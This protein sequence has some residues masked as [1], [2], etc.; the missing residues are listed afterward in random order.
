[1]YKL[2]LYLIALFLIAVPYLQLPGMM[3][4][5]SK[6]VFQLILLLFTGLV[7]LIPFIKK[8]KGKSWQPSAKLAFGSTFTVICFGL[9]FT[10]GLISVFLASNI[11]FATL[12]FS[13]YFLL[14][15]LVYI[16]A[17]ATLKQH[18]LL[19]KLI[20]AT[21]LIY[22]SVYMVIFF[23]N[24]ISS[25]FNP[26]IAM[27]PEKYDFTL[28]IDDVVLTGKE[29][30]YFDNI[31]FFNHTQTWTLPLLV[32]LL[33]YFQKY[34][35]NILVS[36]LLFLL[37]S[38]WWMLLFVTN[39]RGA[40]FGI[41]V[42]L[43]I[44]T[45][46]WRKDIYAILKN[47]VTS[48]VTGGALYYLLFILPVDTIG[49]TIFRI[50]S[51]RPHRFTGALEVWWQNPFFGL[52]PMHYAEIG[53]TQFVGHPHNFYLQFLSEWGIFAFVAFTALI[54]VGLK[55]VFKNYRT[56]NTLSNNRIIYSSLTWS[57]LAGLIHAFFS[58]V[59]MTPM[60]QIWFVL[61]A[62]WFVG[63]QRKSITEHAI[64]IRYNHLYLIYIFFLF[65][66]LWMVSYDVF[67]LAE[68]YEEFISDYPYE[69]FRP[70]FWV[71]GLFE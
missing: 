58:G 53:K 9:I 20:F 34:N 6:R 52:G 69:I 29:V 54:F 2:I 60:S 18:H 50:E 57:L 3:Q 27:W 25:F 51:S 65:I 21:A 13:F 35:S 45:F 38:C 10:A 64:S 16:L 26:M 63:Y 28:T 11:R 19:G 46:L 24:Y 70:R 62:A 14:L 4:Y 12:E 39:V 48:F 23:G 66:V 42:S 32:G 22:S 33:T 56:T 71:Q 47:A 36:V 67:S 44:I 49:R 5:D 37:I 31:R 61:I 41:I 17:P 15:A 1:M 8:L 40:F 68:R 43:G 30:L 55:F 59:M 7:I